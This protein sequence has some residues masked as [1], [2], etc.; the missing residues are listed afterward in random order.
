MFTKAGVQNATV[1]IV[2]PPVCCCVFGN[3]RSLG[4]VTE[5]G[6]TL[7]VDLARYRYSRTLSS[8]TVTVINMLIPGI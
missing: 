2:G 3:T 4:P 8:G 5:A 1:V 7:A 6:E